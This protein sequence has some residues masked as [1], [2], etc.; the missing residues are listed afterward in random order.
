MRFESDLTKERRE[1]SQ[2]VAVRRQA[3]TSV[4]VIDDDPMVL[5][6]IGRTLRR[7]G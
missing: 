4:L 2:T 6:L 7:E 1:R 3:A 5:D